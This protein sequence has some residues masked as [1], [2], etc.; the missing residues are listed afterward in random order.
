MIQLCQPA[1]RRNGQNRRPK[2]GKA[3]PVR[4]ARVTGTMRGVTRR[5]RR[6]L[7][8]C[9]VALVVAGGVTAGAVWWRWDTARQPTVDDAVATMNRAVA[10]TAVAAGPQVA[11]A[12]SGVVRSAVCRINPVRRGG[13]FT[14]GADLYTR[15]GT[16]DE[17]IT[18][19]ARRLAVSYPVRR[20]A[21][22]SGVRPLRADMAGGIQ[23][24]VRGLGDGWLRVSARTGC[25]LGAAAAPPP[26]SPDDAGAAGVSALF[27]RLGTRPA[28]VTRHRLECADG[29][30][31]TV[32]AVS[33]P[34]DSSALRV[35][36]AAAVPTTAHRF[37]SAE[38]NRLVYRD[39]DV[40]V[41]VAASDDGTAVTGQYTT[42]C[43]R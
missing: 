27:A 37:T 16:E 3:A 18:A 14:A 43:A 33:G 30:I 7:V 19:M 31:V 25:S 1:A 38:A 42:A 17:L 5:P 6:L 10:D 4:A 8:I 29:V 9:A 39:G 20:G 32:A 2:V 36:L 22:V 26:V 28:S 40:S 13:I 23:L 35:R 11:V 21:A 15:R 12:V 34:V 41:V 24:S